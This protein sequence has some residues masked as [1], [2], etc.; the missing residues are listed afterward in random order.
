MKKAIAIVLA[1]IA[2][3]ALGST[4]A[5]TES[6]YQEH[7]A[8]VTY[9]EEDSDTVT[10]TDENGE[11]WDMD[12]IEDWMLGDHARLITDDRGTPEL[13]DDVIVSATYTG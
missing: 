10:F 4:A 1:L 5:S 8:V 7:T 2:G 9:I 11:L 3:I 13:Y 12:G 6:R